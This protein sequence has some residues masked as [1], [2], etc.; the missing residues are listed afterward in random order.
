VLHH[1]DLRLK[2]L[3]TGPESGRVAGL[4]DW[5]NALSSPPPY[6]DLSIAL[7]DLGIDEK[8]AFL[9]GFGMTPRR[10]AGAARFMRLLNVA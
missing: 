10:F 1:G 7:H 6:W 4:L 5:E 8:E 3:I 9:I 2:N